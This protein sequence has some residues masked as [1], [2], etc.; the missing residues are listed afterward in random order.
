MRNDSRFR[1]LLR[2]AVL[3][4]VVLGAAACTDDSPLQPGDD[5]VGNRPAPGSRALGMMEITIAGIGTPE[6]SASAAAITPGRTLPGATQPGGPSFALLPVEG[7]GE[8]ESAESGIEL[9]NIST[10]SFTEYDDDGG[11]RYVWATYRVRNATARGSFGGGTAYNVARQNLTFLAVDDAATIGQTAISTLRR[12]DGGKANDAIAAT[13]L[14]TGAVHRDPASGAIVSSAPDVLQILTEAE[15]DAIDAPAGVSVFPFGFVVNA[16]IVGGVR[17]LAADPAENEFDGL[18]TFAFKVP[19]QESSTDD[20]FTISFRALAVEDTETRITQSLEEQDAAGR[21]AVEARAAQLGARQVTLLPGGAYGGG[22]PSRQICTARTAGRA[23]APTTVLGTPIRVLALSSAPGPDPGS[24]TFTATFDG[25]LSGFDHESFIVRGMQSGVKSTGAAY[26][27][28]GTAAITTPAASFFPGEMVEVLLKDGE[29]CVDGLPYVARLHVASGAARGSFTG[30]SY[31]PSGEFPGHPV[32]AD[33]TGNGRLEIGAPNERSYDFTLWTLNFDTNRFTSHVTQL[34]PYDLKSATPN[35]IAAAGDMNN[36]GTMDLVVA[37]GVNDD[38][39][40]FFGNGY[41]TFAAGPRIAV[42]GTPTAITLGDM[43]GDGALDFVVANR[44]SNRVSVGLGNGDGTFQP[45]VDYGLGSFP[46]DTELADLDGDGRLDLIALTSSSF[47][48]R[49]GNGDGTF[50]PAH[51]MGGLKNAVALAIADLDDDGIL[52]IAVADSDGNAVTGMVAIFLGHGNG[53]GF[54]RRATYVFPGDY[55]LNDIVAGDLDGDGDKDL[56]TTNG[57]PGA[58]LVLT[59]D[60][61]ADFATHRSSLPWANGLALA[62]MN[63]DGKL[64]IV[65]SEGVT[66]TANIGITWGQ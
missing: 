45:L 27:G 53:I 15:V 65:F 16:P 19:L 12:F 64:D 47:V 60:G 40:V 22:I 20:P 36:D 57:T 55:R 32:V 14:P 26:D 62:D 66:V 39:L 44:T 8:G 30:N 17:T 21:A 52:D 43:N 6:M 28:N 41:G 46:K 38:V 33:W 9:Q 63:R 10:G 61:S 4:L 56:V 25:A 3:P 1:S 54:D 18:V 13:L 24:Y 2:R 34:A 35:M 48:I 58:M 29:A 31:F 37:I 42:G 50:G 23:A 7:I 59:N 5:S 49:L 51:T 11:V